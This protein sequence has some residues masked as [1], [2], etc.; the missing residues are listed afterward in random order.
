MPKELWIAILVVLGLLILCVLFK[1]RK[2]IFKKK[3][4]KTKKVEVKKEEVKKPEKT[5]D[6]RIS[7]EQR[8]VKVKKEENVN[9]NIES[10]E[11]EDSE[12]R[13]YSTGAS[14]AP[15]RN[16]RR[17]FPRSNMQQN[18]YFGMQNKS[19]REQINDLSPEMKVILFGN[20]MGKK[21][22]QF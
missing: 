3:T 8:E 22:D 18:S 10:V 17:T 9:A 20:V 19:I 15:Q 16:F 2:K 14:F 21:D 12:E 13:V 4:P 6:S 5:A 1:F 11:I 7:F